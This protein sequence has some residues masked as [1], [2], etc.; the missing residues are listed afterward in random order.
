M[1]QTTIQE[2]NDSGHKA[3]HSVF[4]LK[5]KR[6]NKHTTKDI[7]ILKLKLRERIQ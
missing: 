7:K 6:F 1:D 4:G 3:H 5:K 2:R